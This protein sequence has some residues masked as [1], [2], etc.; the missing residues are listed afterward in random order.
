MRERKEEMIARKRAGWTMSRIGESFGLTASAVQRIV[1]PGIRATEPASL[2]APPDL[3]GYLGAPED[4]LAR[5]AWIQD[6]L[7][8]GVAVEEI[9]DALEVTPRRSAMRRG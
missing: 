1:G 3:A 5:R 2:H 7:A 4:K 6:K 8:V 9:A